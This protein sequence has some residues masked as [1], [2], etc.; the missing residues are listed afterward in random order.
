MEKV[1]QQLKGEKG[2]I[3]TENGPL[4]WLIGVGATGKHYKLKE[5]ERGVD[6]EVK[7]CPCL[8][9]LGKEG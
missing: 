3:G 2:T 5:K 4:V 9:S 8:N 7:V 1:K 6:S